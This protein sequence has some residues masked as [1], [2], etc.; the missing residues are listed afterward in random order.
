MSQLIFGVSFISW[1]IYWLIIYLHFSKIYPIQSI[2]YIINKLPLY[3]KL[4][5]NKQ[6][7]YITS[8]THALLSFITS[9]YILLFIPNEQIIHYNIYH[10]IVGITMSY[11]IMDLIIVMYL[12]PNYI[13]IVHHIAAD[14][15]IGT[16][17]LYSHLCPHMYPF[18]IILAEITNPLQLIF[19]YLIMT[20]Q[21][22]SNYFFIIST[23]FTYI[24]TFVRILIV[25]FIYL[26]SYRNIY[27]IPNIN[28]YHAYIFDISLIT[29][30]LGGFI[31]NYNI[32]KGYYIKVYLPLINQ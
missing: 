11:Y 20:K 3:Q 29:G 24:F 18:T 5:K 9:S 30:I 6:I 21:T 13:F 8:M 22:Q 28:R 2:T 7:S 15:I 31:W 19:T 1:I 32:I 17:Y 27:I 23:I 4:E 12:I 26:D 10:I 25:P 16:F 14:I